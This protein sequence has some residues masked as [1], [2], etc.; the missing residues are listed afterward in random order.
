MKFWYKGIDMKQTLLMFLFVFSTMAA[1]IYVKDDQFKI[2]LRSKPATNG[3]FVAE[4]PTGTAM[5]VLS[6]SNGW[7]NV[8][9]QETGKTGWVISSFT[10]GREPWQKKYEDLNNAT[11][12][13]QSK[14]E[15]LTKDKELLNRN[16]TSLQDSLDLTVKE[17]KEA[18][19]TIEIQTS[20]SLK[21]WFLI[22]AA[23]M[24]LGWIMA[25]ISLPKGK[26]KKRW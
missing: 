2:V 10:M 13:M 12:E 8:K 20:K 16:L 14:I 4:L 11:S 6:R 1:T 24:L 5:T 23:V 26:K 3:R 21:V 15:N 22:G 9:V 17:L 25:H 19:A 7:T 18:K